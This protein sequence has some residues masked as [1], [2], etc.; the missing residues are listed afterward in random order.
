V[1][2]AARGLRDMDSGAERIVDPAELARVR[3]QARIVHL[4]SFLSALMIT[5]IVGVL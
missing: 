4:K 3:R 5:A 1:R 2:L